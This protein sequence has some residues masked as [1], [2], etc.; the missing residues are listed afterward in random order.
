V[1]ISRLKKLL[2]D[3]LTMAFTI[4]EQQ[5]FANMLDKNLDMH[6]LT[7]YPPNTIIPV[8]EGATQIVNHFFKIG[9]LA[10]LL[11]L[12]IGSTQRG[13][14]GERVSFNNFKAVIKEMNECGFVY[15]AD[16]KKIVVTDDKSPRNDWGFLQEDQLY[17]FCFVSID[18]CGN[19]KLVRKYNID[20]IQ[21]T[22]SNYKKMVVSIIEKRN[23]RV[24]MWE[25]DGGVLVF[26]IKDPVND[27]IYSS[28]EILGLMHIF[29][30]T[31]NLLN[32]PV[33]IRIA[34]N[35][36]ETKFKKDA[37]NIHSEPLD[38]V[39]EIEKH[40][41]MPMSISVANHTFKYANQLIK[42][43]FQLKEI[44]GENLHNYQIPVW[45]VK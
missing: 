25:G 9:R 10:Q 30:A 16:I 32:E 12:Y 13:F 7:G 20:D 14:R 4:N 39:R 37:T 18:I 45:R 29:N 15:R 26:H 33:N 40:H 17:N 28:F 44:K 11:E 36:G 22:Y 5:I 34:I 19:T 27:A 2:I 31:M 8:R 21:K 3:D 1:G 35:S 43:F 41:T 23:G 38:R 6:T 42:P 24:W